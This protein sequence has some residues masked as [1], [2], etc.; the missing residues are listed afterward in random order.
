MPLIERRDGRF[1]VRERSEI[2]RLVKYSFPDGVAVDG[3]MPGLAR[4]AAAL[5]ANDHA[6]ARIAA[7]HLQIPDLPGP[8]ARNAMIAEDAL[9]KYA[10]DQSGD[11]N[12]NPALHPARRCAAQ[13]GLVRASRWRPTKPWRI[14][15]ALRRKC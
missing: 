5:N 3:L 7:V 4:I 8:A 10:Q 15:T 1:T 14:E 11:S 2:A 12:W 6:A 13:S 9:I